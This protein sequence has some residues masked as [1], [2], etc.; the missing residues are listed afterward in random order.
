MLR[1]AD[2]PDDLPCNS[3]DHLLSTQHDMQVEPSEARIRN[4]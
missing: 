2:H 1:R 3:L 4:N